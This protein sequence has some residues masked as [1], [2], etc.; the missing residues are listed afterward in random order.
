MTDR[1]TPTPENVANRPRRRI[2][3]LAN[4]LIATGALVISGVA[5]DMTVRPILENGLSSSPASTLVWSY[6]HTAETLGREGKLAQLPQ[7][8]DSQQVAAAYKEIDAE[9]RR[10]LLDL[11]ALGAGTVVLG[12]GF[13]KRRNR[14]K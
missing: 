2:L 9:G 7:E 4:G 8:F 11:G 5:A 12:V 14:I 6:E 3:T 10:K 13:S 1:G